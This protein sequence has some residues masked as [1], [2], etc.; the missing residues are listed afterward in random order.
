M[1][2]KKV[3]NTIAQRGL[4]GAQ[5]DATSIANNGAVQQQQYF[6]DTYKIQKNKLIAEMRH[7]ILNSGP[8]SPYGILNFGYQIGDL[9]D[10]GLR[11]NP[12]FS[13]SYDR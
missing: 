11:G 3:V 9:L 2:L 1:K 13:G 12:A 5:T 6:A 8:E 7:A 10:S 4:I